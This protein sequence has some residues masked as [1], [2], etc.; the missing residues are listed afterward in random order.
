MT[1]GDSEILTLY[2]QV[3]DWIEK[4]HRVAIATV[5]ST[6]GSSPR[7]VGSQLVVNDERK[8]EGSVSGGCVETA[9][10]AAAMEV[11]ESSQPQVLKF[12]VSNDT[13][14]EV[15]LSCGGE[16]QVHVESVESHY[17]CDT[18]SQWKLSDIHRIIEAQND[19]HAIAIVK[20]LDGT[21]RRIYTKVPS[22]PLS[23]LGRAVAEGFRKDA[24][25]LI[26]TAGG[27]VFIQII[28]SPLKLIIV[29]AVHIAKHLIALAQICGFNVVLIDPRRAFTESEFLSETEVITKWP[30][31][32]ISNLKLN[33]RAAVVTLTHDPKIDEPALISALNSEAFYVGALGSRRTHQARC[34]RLAQAGVCEDDIARI[35][36]P[37]GLDIGAQS[38]A[39]IALAIM[40][41]ITQS[42]RHS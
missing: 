29:G 1:N 5:I 35:H 16:I 15:G 22:E 11:I 34:D 19:Q 41:E 23:W 6:W 38:P 14:W 20:S 12:G 25:Q 21:I 17:H 4:G 3:S 26:D 40:G 24:S 9:V 7:P 2:Q 33:A 30:D 42:L 36:A 8:F 31:K 10:I 28:N 32:V 13:A 18:G 37:I 27:K 39:E